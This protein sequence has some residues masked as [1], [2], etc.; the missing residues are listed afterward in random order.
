MIGELF[1]GDTPETETKSSGLSI[2][3]PSTPSSSSSAT[4]SKAVNDS[5]ASALTGELMEDTRSEII[6]AQSPRATPLGSPRAKGDSSSEEED[7]ITGGGKIEVKTEPTAKKLMDPAQIVAAAAAAAKDASM[8][9]AAREKKEGISSSSSSSYNTS[10][11]TN[12]ATNTTV[13]TTVVSTTS[14]YS[15]TNST[16]A[17]S[18]IP[19]SNTSMAPPSP[20]V[21]AKKL[22][23]SSSSSSSSSSFSFAT[24]ATSNQPAPSP[25]AGPPATPRTADSAAQKL[26]HGERPPG[27]RELPQSPMGA[28]I[29]KNVRKM[30]Q[31]EIIAATAGQRTFQPSDAPEPEE[32]VIRTVS[33]I[34]VPHS[35]PPRLAARTV[36]P[37]E[38]P[39]QSKAIMMFQRDT[40]DIDQALFAMYVQEYNEKSDGSNRRMAYIAYLDSVSYMRPKTLRTKI[41]HQILL[42]YMEW[43]KERGF[44]AVYIWACPPPHKRDDY[45]LHV[46]PDTQRMPSAE[47]LRRWYHKMIDEG[48][49]SGLV[50]EKTSL[51][52]EHLVDF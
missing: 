27:S 40:S 11:E 13:A 2:K 37:K 51:Y 3:A 45:I 42:A 50:V 28:Y 9:E 38:L 46:H 17:T 6:P 25:R 31:G 36:Y 33:N 21:G 16:S 20:V 5:N 22:V 35:L 23:I 14:T 29:E 15:A 32:I 12:T 1:V 48:S 10:A 8:K 26:L 47:R 4:K 49:R 43:I 30:I 44:C 39:Y 24:T 18:A 34:K 41:Y 52:H 19:P 7:N